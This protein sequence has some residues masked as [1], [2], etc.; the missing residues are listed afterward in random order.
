M[1][2]VAP[3]ASARQITTAYRALVRL[4]HPDARPAERDSAERL[5]EVVAA[6]TVLHDP[7][8]RAVYDARHGTGR[9]GAPVG[10]TAGGQRVPVRVVPGNPAV[11]AT[12]CLGPSGET[13]RPGGPAV[14]AGPVR[15]TPRGPSAPPDDLGGLWEWVNRL[16]E[17]DPWL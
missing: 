2:G 10:S 8:L 5:D 15:F 17:V 11:T 1:L 12:W 13:R 6:Y 7:E 14:R 16:W 4:L 3:S 9:P